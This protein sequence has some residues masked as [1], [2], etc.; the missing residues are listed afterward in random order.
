[1]DLA[2][3]QAAL[4][5]PRVGSYCVGAA[6]Y[7][8]EGNLLATGYTGELEGNTHAEEVCFLKID[9]VPTGC[10]LYTTMEPCSYRLSG[11]KSC[12][13]WCLEKGIARVV[14]G[15]REPPD[16]VT[17]CGVEILRDR[18]QINENIYIQH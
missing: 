15:I 2:R 6:L 9:K 12:T 8:S 11:K 13:E 17:C 4:A 18:V 10:T 7:D 5:I 1:M 14:Y 16:L 3:Q